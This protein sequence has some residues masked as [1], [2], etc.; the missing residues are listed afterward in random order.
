MIIYGWTIIKHNE[1]G[2]PIEVENI[3]NRLFDIAE[4]LKDGASL[5]KSRRE[6]KS[7]RRRI[8]RRKHR[9]ERVKKLI[10]KY[11]ILT[12]QEIENLYNNTYDGNIYSLR[13]N[14]LDKKLTNLDLSRILINMVKKRGYKSNVELDEEAKDE[15]GKVLTN[16]KDNKKIMKEKGYR[17]ISEMY[18]Q[19]SKFK[20][21]LPNNI[22]INKIRNTTGKYESTVLRSQIR[23]EIMLILNKQKQLNPLISSS[24][25]KEYL[26][27]FDS[28]RAYD[29]GTQKRYSTK[30][31]D[32]ML[33]KCIYEKKNRA[34]K[35][36]YS[37]EYFDLLKQ[38]NNIIIEKTIIKNE[39]KKTER[40]KFTKE[41]RKK[42]I[43]LAKYQSIIRYY[44]IR[45]ELELSEYE[46]FV[47]IKYSSISEF[48]NS[49][50]RSAEQKEKI[51]GFP[52][53][54]K[55]KQMLYYIDSNIIDSLSI[56]QLNDIAYILTVYKSNEKR[57]EQFNLKNINLPMNAIQ[58]LLKISFN[59]ISY[60]SL[61]AINKLI[62]LLEDGF[63]YNEALEKVYPII[64]T[65][66]SNLNNEILN[67]VCRRAIS[68]S[69]KVIK[70][71]TLNYG[72]PDS[73]NIIF[74]YNLGQNKIN[75]NNI[76]K[77][78]QENLLKTSKIKEELIS[79]EI[80]PTGKNI[81]KYK[82]WKEQSNYCIYSGKRIDL[83]DLFTDKVKVDYIIPFYMCFDDTY[84]NKILAFSDEIEQ[85]KDLLPYLYILNSKKDIKEYETRVEMLIREYSKKIRLLKS[86][87]T[88]NEII[89]WRNRNIQDKQYLSKW[90]INYL[91][92]NIEFQECEM[93]NKKILTISPN[94][95]SYIRRKL[96]I[97][98]DV[99]TSLVVS[100]VSHELLSQIILYN[101][102]YYINKTAFPFPWSNFQNSLKKLP[103]IHVSRSP[104]RKAKG[105]AHDETLRSMK[106]C[107]DSIKSISR[108]PIKK[109]KLNSNGEI[110]GFSTESRKNDL[111]LYNSL[112]EKL[113]MSGGEGSNAFISTF[114]RVKNDKTLGLPVNKVKVEANTKLP[115]ILK[116][117][118]I[119][120]NGT[121]IRLDIFKVKDIGF[122]FIPIYVADTIKK[123]LPRKA[124]L[125]QKPY[126]DWT[127][128]ND[129][130]FIF[131]IYPRD[132]IYIKSKEPIKLHSIDDES[133][134]SVNETFAYYI[135]A[136]IS[137]ATISIS[138][139]NNKYIAKIGIKTLIDLKKYDV[140]ILGNYHEIKI[141]QKRLNFNI[142]NNNKKY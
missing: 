120:T 45:Q 73:I 4:N 15:D 40:R 94:L 42:L 30:Q 22:V 49:I 35:A 41:E 87:I 135:R 75:R 122:Y 61:E 70:A 134:I 90:I 28:Q 95:V 55:I 62:P 63:T 14:G 99:P 68:Q 92:E 43:N 58:E 17:S 5:S 32:K 105:S 84:K 13:I 69:I 33:G 44:D 123:K 3:G 51:E 111:N 107:K 27:I 80:E 23:E 67:P 1:E 118:T 72:K 78:K 140:D 46:R 139:E 8:R 56:N 66:I 132:L 137:S 138:N 21:F 108:I 19:D 50:N 82:L 39:F 100:T 112:K 20:K 96:E 129:N 85:K 83:K 12:N 2:M 86:N 57:I 124:C 25:I 11:N 34:V 52:A 114:Y 29:E 48:S 116:N 131:S 106:I 47:N 91:N 119:A 130:N 141:P 65:N 101:K 115:V 103:Y 16:T 31:I 38:L 79:L 81:L 89:S 88:K 110:N 54:F 24:F 102:N 125:S 142:N 6:N 117:N 127:I 97:A 98:N 121:I 53:Y 74:N 9:I 126:K 104:R 7:I 37:Y 71:I 133:E 77:I 113:E 128:M 64:S 26:E 60:I 76:K 36:S 10:L 93:Y 136:D 18:L 109:L 59:D